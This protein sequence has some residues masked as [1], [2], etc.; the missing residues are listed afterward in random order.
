[1]KLELANFL[2][3]AAKFLGG[4]AG[5]AFVG[6]YAQKQAAKSQAVKEL[7]TLKSEYKEFAEFTKCELEAS[8]EDRKACQAENELLRD[9][10]GEL[11]IHVNDLT[12]AM[13]NAI[14]TPKEKRKGLGGTKSKGDAGK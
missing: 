12:I 8:R 10:I 7:Q 3:E 1:M 5:G 2:T 13:H 6:Y 14:G 9:E 11:K 4:G